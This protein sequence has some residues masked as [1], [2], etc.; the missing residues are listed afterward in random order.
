MAVQLVV[1]R[2][3]Y[4]PRSGESEQCPVRPDRRFCSKDWALP[5][6]FRRHWAEMLGEDQRPQDVLQLI[7]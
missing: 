6:H 4:T 5:H 2:T 1:K 3:R 7:I